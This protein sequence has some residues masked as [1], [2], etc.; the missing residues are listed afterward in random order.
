MNR[1]PAV[2]LVTFITL[3][4]CGNPKPYQSKLDPLALQ[5]MQTQEFETSKSIL[6][7]STI[8]VFQDTGFIIE[9]GDLASGIITAKS[10]T[11]TN[12]IGLAGSSSVTTRAT[13]FLE[14][15]RIGHA[16]LR[17]NYVEGRTRD[18]G[19]G[20]GAS[21]EQPNESPAYYENV[22]NKIREAVFL[23]EAH[24]ASDKP[25]DK[26]SVIPSAPAPTPATKPSDKPV[27]KP[28]PAAKAI[29]LPATPK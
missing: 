5:A 19:Y 26:P 25:V 7:A 29:P 16:M 27:K 9:T 22:F 2:V 13:A 8:S 4:G 20:P 23:R 17:L 10:P 6:F 18:L 28:A 24:K 1:L 12:Q 3:V 15:S 11:S 21:F 14:E